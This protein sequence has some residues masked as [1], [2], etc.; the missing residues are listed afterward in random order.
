MWFPTT[1]HAASN[2]IQSNSRDDVRVQDWHSEENQLV[3]FHITNFVVKVTS[4][5]FRIESSQKDQ[6]PLTQ[7]KQIQFSTIDFFRVSELKMKRLLTFPVLM[8]A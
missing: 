2:G 8:C 1:K 3:K 7:S 6:Y 4:R 5:L